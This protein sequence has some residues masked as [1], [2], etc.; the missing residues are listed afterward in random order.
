MR[1]IFPNM[2]ILSLVLVVFT[3]PLKAQTEFL[4]NP[5]FEGTPGTYVPYDWE[6]CKNDGEWNNNF[7]DPDF[8]PFF[9]DEVHTDTLYNKDGETL[10]LLRARSD[11]YGELGNSSKSG[12]YEHMS[13]RLV[14]SFQKDSTYNLVVWLACPT[15]FK[16]AD[17]VA[18][19]TGFPI[20][21]QV[22]G[23][24]R[25]C[26]AND[27]N[28]L[29][30]TLITNN[31]W[32]LYVLDL[33]PRKYYDY[34]YFRVYWDDKILEEQNGKYNG[35][36]LL[37]KASVSKTCKTK[38]L[39][40]DTLYYTEEP[41]LQL[42]APD[43]YNYEWGPEGFLSNPIVRSP[44]LTSYCDSVHV[45]SMDVD[46]CKTE[47]NFKILFS[48]DTLYHVKEGNTIYVYYN[49]YQDVYLYASTGVNWA[50][51]NT[52]PLSAYDIQNPILTGYDSIINVAVTDKYGC[53]FNEVFKIL[54]DCDILYQSRDYNHEKQVV[55]YGE[56]IMIEPDYPGSHYAWN[57][58]EN[59]NC[60][61]CNRIEVTAYN[62]ISYTVNYYDD[63]SCELRETFPIE[64]EL[65]IPNVITPAIAGEGDGQNDTFFIPGL[66]EGS[67][68]QIFEKTGV[69][70]F[71][72]KPYNTTNWWN[73]TDR[74]G[75]PVR[76]GTYWYA[77]DIPG[78]DKPIT[79]FIF[80]VR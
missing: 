68:I 39:P 18:P 30:D 1:N 57:P 15:K 56:T 21:F 27:S 7:N 69:L 35:I 60:S 45:T 58:A 20:R 24:D 66:P 14:R 48:C 80:V 73:G 37:D 8:L 4:I 5:S 59:L 28:I 6:T 31:E 46:F 13:S 12:S 47:K 40:T 71:K 9:T 75:K 70:V 65:E 50:W 23:A 10:C 76:S 11:H 16:V 61:D 42:Q 79:G 2:I 36:I 34:I 54:L 49:I 55:K 41:P 72:A 29:S 77:L 67:S 52:K 17:S 32:K 38:Y 25:Y 33:K 63:F 78:N 26:V 43:D 44:Y 74:N 62:N 51:D 3:V 64:I 19:D 22:F 53:G